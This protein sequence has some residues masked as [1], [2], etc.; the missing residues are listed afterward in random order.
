MFEKDSQ[1]VERGL[2]RPIEQ[3]KNKPKFRL[4]FLKGFLEEIQELENAIDSVYFGRFL[5]N[6]VGV[7]LDKIG[8]RL[9]EE[10]KGREDELYRLWLGVRVKVNRSFGRVKDIIEILSLV[11]DIEFHYREHSIGPAAFIIE[12]EYSHVSTDV[13]WFRTLENLV[14]EAKSAGVAYSLIFPTR[15]TSITPE[16]FYPFRLCNVGD[17]SDPH[18]G[19]SFQ[20]LTTEFGGYLS[21]VRTG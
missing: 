18:L 15:T 1:H 14:R 6:A 5:E 20:Q 7:Q 19:L 17:V 9:Q 4:L 10:R 13:E 21:H 8:R 12:F 16:A 2:S 11:T 3:F